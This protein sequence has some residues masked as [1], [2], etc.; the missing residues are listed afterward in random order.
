MK[1]LGIYYTSQHS[2]ELLY[3]QFLVSAERDIQ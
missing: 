1:Y 2:N 3:Y